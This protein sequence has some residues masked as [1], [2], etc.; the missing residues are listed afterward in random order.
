[1]NKARRLPKQSPEELARHRDQLQQLY[2]GRAL[3]KIPA[4][5]DV[6]KT[7]VPP[8]ASATEREG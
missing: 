4:S 8:L 3:P 1:M 2:G 6:E 5:S 7:E